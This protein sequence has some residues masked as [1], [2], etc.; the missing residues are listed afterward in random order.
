L[1]DDE[2]RLN[3]KRAE[4]MRALQ[5]QN[6]QLQTIIIKMRAM[7]GW[8]QTHMTNNY[9]KVVRLFFFYRQYICMYFTARK[10]QTSVLIFNCPPMPTS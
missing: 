8:R 2:V 1:T 9:L 7:H 3:L 6:H 4:Q 10:M 5:N